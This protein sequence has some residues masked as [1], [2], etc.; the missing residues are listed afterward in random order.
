MRA[1]EPKSAPQIR[2]EAKKTYQAEK[3]FRKAVQKIDERARAP[4]E[5]N[6]REAL[7]A[8]Q[9]AQNQALKMQQVQLD[10]IAQHFTLQVRPIL[11]AELHRVRAVCELT[12]EQQIVIA[13]VGRD[14]MKQVVD[15]Y[16][17]YQQMRMQ[18][19]V[20]ATANSNPRITIQEA[21][22]KAV[23][24]HLPREQASRY[25]DE[26]TKRDDFWKQTTVRNLVARLDQDLMLSTEQR[27]DISESLLSHWDPVWAASVNH[28][29]QGNSYSPDLPA[30][31][32]SPL[33]DKTQMKVWH[34]TPRP[35]F[36]DPGLT[37]VNGINLVEGNPLID[38]ELGAEKAA[39][40]VP[41]VKAAR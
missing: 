39:N 3:T 21:L 35:A 41:Q 24:L 15:K 37:F 16:V 9:E 8:M 29:L 20:Q 23:A 38:L 13:E 7:K 19:M 14:A 12:E 28:F 5:K 27:E 22:L 40:E 11:A 17:K 25:R 31:L 2:N 18:G 36:G 26:V 34:E 6:Q 33:L 4:L 30:S 10:R 1:Q 32:V